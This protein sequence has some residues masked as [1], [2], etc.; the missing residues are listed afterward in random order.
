MP[1]DVPYGAASTYQTWDD[2]TYQRLKD[3][4]NDLRPLNKLSSVLFKFKYA[5]VAMAAQV[6]TA[7]LWYPAAICYFMYGTTHLAL[8]LKQNQWKIVNLGNI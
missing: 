1:I 6:I 4:W 7:Y 5:N 8:Y 3:I 2:V